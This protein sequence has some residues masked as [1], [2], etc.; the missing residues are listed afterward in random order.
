MGSKYPLL[1]PQQIIKVLTI[2][3]FEKVSQ[4]GSHVKYKK[5]GNSK[6]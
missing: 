3:G 4:K 1:K 2:L 6:I 5:S